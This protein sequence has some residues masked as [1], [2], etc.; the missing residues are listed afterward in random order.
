MATDTLTMG[1]ERHR[2]DTRETWQQCNCQKCVD[3]QQVF[4]DFSRE[5]HQH[6]GNYLKRW[7]DERLREQ[8]TGGKQD[9]YRM[10]IVDRGSSN[11]KCVTRTREGSNAAGKLPD[12]TQMVLN[13]TYHTWKTVIIWKE[14]RKRL[15]ESEEAK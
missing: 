12:I 6:G 10:N 5:K 11:L 9:G 13:L 4:D 1:A 3:G 8:M 15:S 2:H 14:Y 7:M